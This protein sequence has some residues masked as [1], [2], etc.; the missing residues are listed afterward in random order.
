MPSDQKICHDHSFALKEIK[1]ARW[2]SRVDHRSA[3]NGRDSR[4][5][6]LPIGQHQATVVPAGAARRWDV[7]FTPGNTECQSCQLQR[8]LDGDAFRRRQCLIVYG[9]LESW[10]GRVVEHQFASYVATNYRTRI[11]PYA[12]LQDGALL[13]AATESAI[14]APGFAYSSDEKTQTVNGR[15]PV[16]YSRCA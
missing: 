14:H 5:R 1:V 3:P 16:G 8:P 9:G 15:R 4:P 11:A 12:S 13:R 10:T 7:P 6:R 2:Q